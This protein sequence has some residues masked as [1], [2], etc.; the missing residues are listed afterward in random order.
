MTECKEHDRGAQIMVK[1][2]IIQLGR[3]RGNQV[4]VFQRMGKNS[5][6]R[7]RV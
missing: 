3:I 2:R 7:G 4:E 1:V 6:G 5:Q